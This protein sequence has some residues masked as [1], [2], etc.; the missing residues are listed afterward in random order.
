MG[1]ACCGPAF[2]RDRRRAGRDRG[3][4]KTDQLGNRRRRNRACDLTL[5]SREQAR[6]LDRRGVRH[7]RSRS[8][9]VVVVDVAPAP[10]FSGL[11]GLD[12]RV[13]GFLEVSAGVFVF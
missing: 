3:H 10:V 2:E 13:L 7:T 11:E 4:L 12:D 5:N 1:L 8:L 6:V 9:D